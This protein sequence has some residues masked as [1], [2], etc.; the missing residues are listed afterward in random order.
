MTGPVTGDFDAPVAL[1]SS[2]PAVIGI[3][4]GLSVPVGSSSVT[5]QLFGA[6]VAKNTK[7]TITAAYDTVMQS[8]SVTVT[9]NGDPLVSSISF[10]PNPVKA[11]V[12]T[13]GTVTLT[14]T[15]PTGG[16]I[17]D[18]NATNNS[19]V[20]MPASILVPAGSKS[21]TFN[22]PTFSVSQSTPIVVTANTGSV[23]AQTTLTVNP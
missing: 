2:N 18:I 5:F 23:S 9:P 7:V 3:V 4:P 15:A 21:T 11:G 6:D 14:K 8:A 12:T 10:S 13:V 1:E 22:V 16:T 20:A 19:A 17:V